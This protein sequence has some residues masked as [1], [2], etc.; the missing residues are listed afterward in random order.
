[1]TILCYPKCATC[2]KALDLLT[3]L[4]LPY[5]V[6]D[7]K[8]ENPTYD[9]LKEW[10]ERS[11]LP[12]S[13]FFN[14]SGTAYRALNLR[15]RLPDMSAEEQLRLLASDGMLVRRP[16]LVANKFVL[17][18]FNET[19]WITALSGAIFTGLSELSDDDNMD[20]AASTAEM[21]EDFFAQLCLL[22]GEPHYTLP[23]QLL[24]RGG[25]AFEV[26]SRTILKR[27]TVKTKEKR[28]E[29]IVKKLSD[30]EFLK[31][32]FSELLQEEW[33]L[34]IEACAEGGL[35]SDEIEPV[36]CLPLISYGIITVY[37]GDN[38]CHFI[39]PEE[40]KKII[41]E[42]KAE[43]FEEE[44]RHRWLLSQFADASVNLY[45]FLAID[46]FIELFNAFNERHTDTAEVKRVL[47]KSADLDCQYT[48]HN[49]YLAHEYLEDNDFN[50]ILPIKNTRK[51]FPR[52][53]PD[54]AEFLRWAEYPFY[55]ES[56]ETRKL[57]TW[58]S[59]H[60]IDAEEIP[61]IVLSV[62]LTIIRDDLNI[63]GILDFL[64]D[65]DVQFRGKNDLNNFLQIIL[66]L[67]NNTRMWRLYGN[68]PNEQSADT[69]GDVVIQKGQLDLTP[70]KKKK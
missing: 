56:P 16:L 47:A 19:E 36:A 37:Q 20:P 70:R 4:G 2:K 43:G 29:A 35:I 24:D 42:L 8:A 18:G 3:E 38:A 23:E 21:I 48:I 25:E 39:V 17:A 64:T 14:T 1:M 55:A 44:L 53:T 66:E 65:N 69:G 10:F 62:A 49:K 67:N 57:G 63:Q 11:G 60:K 15:E 50:D 12:L 22:D 68:T 54:R 52:Y 58:L 45:G 28:L 61:D 26:V 13:R 31:E 32:F 41:F 46:E 7:I 40:V 51:A 27:G 33:N 59:K 34:L 6:R 9:E 5:T 30:K